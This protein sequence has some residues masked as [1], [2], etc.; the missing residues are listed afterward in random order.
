[1]ESDDVVTI[2]LDDPDIPKLSHPLLEKLG[3]RRPPKGVRLPKWCT[4]VATETF[5]NAGRSTL[6]VV[7]RG[8]VDVFACALVAQCDK[9]KLAQ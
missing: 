5:D 1:M 4:H 7:A 3:Y 8:K 9:L 6:T 2:Y